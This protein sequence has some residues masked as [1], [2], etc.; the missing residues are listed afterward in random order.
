MYAADQGKM[1]GT[2]NTFMASARAGDVHTKDYASVYE[3]K[4]KDLDDYKRAFKDKFPMKDESLVGVVILVGKVCKADICADH[5]MFMIHCDGLLEGCY[6]DAV[7][8]SSNTEDPTVE[9]ITT[10]LDSILSAEFSEFDTPNKVGK[11]L[12]FQRE[13]LLSVN[14][15]VLMHN[16][17]VVHL[18]AYTKR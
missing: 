17:E 3:A 2:V 5:E 15:N 14:G 11:T 16:N 7:S 10:F 1:W 9:A 13:G 6:L 12:M 8:L 18:I 4:Q